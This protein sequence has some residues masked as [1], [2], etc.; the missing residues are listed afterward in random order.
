MV[1]TRRVSTSDLIRTLAAGNRLMG[2]DLLPLVE[3]ASPEEL[4]PLFTAADQ[5]RR[6]MVGDAVH[7]RALIEFSNYCRANCLYC[8]LRRENRNLARY[9]LSLEE[10]EGLIAEAY[11]LGFGTVV[12]QSGED[13]W[14]DADRMAR[15]IRYAKSLGLA[16]TLSL[17]ERSPEEVAYW[18]KEGADRYLLRHETANPALHRR[19]RPGRSLEGRVGL[20]RYLKELGYQIG[21]GFMVGLPGQEAADLVA[22]LELLVE[23]EADMVGIGPFI[24]HPDTPLAGAPGGRVLETVKMVALARLLLPEALIPAT[25][26][27]GS[28][29]PYGRENALEAGANVVMPSLTPKAVRRQ[30]ALYPGRICLDETGE[31]CRACLEARLRRLGRTVATGPGHSLKWERRN[32]N[33]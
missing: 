16:V 6:R 21:A 15:L 26:A 29:D 18:R 17:G 22:D 8:G 25:T 32:R 12:L 33:G 10:I 3:L 20:L 24:P 7:L 1:R 28:L 2:E 27:L 9:R 30:Y 19:L 14:Y 11:R 31:Q 4:A 23:L 5:V 13:L